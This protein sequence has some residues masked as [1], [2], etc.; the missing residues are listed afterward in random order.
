MFSAGLIFF[1]LLTG[2]KPFRG[3]DEAL[4]W[5]NQH[6]SVEIP[7][8]LDPVAKDLLDGMLKRSPCSRLSAL[9]ALQ[10]PYLVNI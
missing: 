2:R 8:S 5:A 9:Q 1:L 10:H 6:C 3:K 7:E 4:R